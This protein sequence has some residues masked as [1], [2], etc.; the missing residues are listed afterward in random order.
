MIVEKIVNTTYGALEQVLLEL[1][2]E[3]S[4]GI[5][6]FGLPYVVYEN[7]EF[8]AIVSLPARPKDEMMYGGHFVVAEKMVEGRGVTSQEAFYKLLQNASHKEVQAA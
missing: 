1:G 7:K 5:N 3:V 8:D 6:E 2:F 4:R